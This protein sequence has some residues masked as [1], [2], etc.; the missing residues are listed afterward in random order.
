MLPFDVTQEMN[1]EGEKHGQN[2]GLLVKYRSSKSQGIKE[3]GG[4]RALKVWGGPGTL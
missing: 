3:P 1:G 4:Q 2:R